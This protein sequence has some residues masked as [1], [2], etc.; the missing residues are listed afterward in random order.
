[1]TCVS[2]RNIAVEKS[3]VES[4]SS[5]CRGVEVLLLGGKISAE[6]INSKDEIDWNC[7][8]ML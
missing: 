7:L 5:F 6:F 3:Y 4:L 1:M 8:G 2:Y